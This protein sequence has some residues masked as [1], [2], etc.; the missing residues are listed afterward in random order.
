MP[1][2][3]SFTNEVGEA[4]GAARFNNQTHRWEAWFGSACY[5]FRSLDDL[6]VALRLLSEQ[7]PRP[8]REED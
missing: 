1:A 8:I 7:G 3:V 4:L 2:L 6:E 5:P